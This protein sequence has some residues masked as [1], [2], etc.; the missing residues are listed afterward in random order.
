MKV[1]RLGSLL[2]RIHFGAMLITLLAIAVMVKLG[3]WQIDRGQEKQMIM[4]RHAAAENYSPITTESLPF[5][6]SAPDEKVSVRATLHPE[7]V[8]YIDNQIHQ[9]RVGYQVLALATNDDLEPNLV[10]VNLGWIPAGQ[11]RADIPEIE[12]AAGEV[13]VRGR[14]RIPAD[15]PFILQEQEFNLGEWPMRIQYPELAKMR[16]QLQFPL[17]DFIVLQDPEADVGFVR[18]WPVVIMT[19]HRH[20]A[21]A[22]QWFG[23]ALAALIIFLVASRHSPKTAGKENS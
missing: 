21:Y 12:L 18:D 13:E 11:N 15:N 16:E 7:Y 3:F 1:L 14:I 8:F 20:Y 9:G 22:V 17:A 4:D 5:L 10:P 2:F 19:P 6:A 23:L